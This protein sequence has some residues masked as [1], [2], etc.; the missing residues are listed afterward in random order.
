MIGVKNMGL[1]LD[2]WK[3]IQEGFSPGKNR[4]FESI[5]SSGNGRMGLRGNHEEDYS[6][7]TFKGTYI[8][9]VYYPDKTR[10]GWWKIGYPEYFAKVLNAI[11]FIGIK[12]R[13]DGKDVDLA[14]CNFSDY[15]RELDM[16]ES[17]LRR[18]FTYIDSSG[19]KYQIR[20]E[21]FLSYHDPDIAAIRYT[22]TAHDKDGELEMLPYLNGDVRNEDANYQEKFWEYVSSRATD[23]ISYLHMRTLKTGFNVAAA[24]AW[25]ITGAG[26]L[27]KEAVNLNNGEFVGTRIKVD[28]SRGE[29][30]ILE[31]YISVIS[32]R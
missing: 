15:R 7:D 2:E 26:I 24:F 21:R 20:T 22:V 4:F 12:V 30:V 5:M 3:I 25:N 14:A 19:S 29:T 10:V 18:S 17:V 27:A 23:S 16:K 1:L 13:I 31:K 8:A 28:I 9:G 32:D 6:G 11:D